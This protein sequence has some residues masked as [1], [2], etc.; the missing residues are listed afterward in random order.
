MVVIATATATG[1]PTAIVIVTAMS[2][3]AE[4]PRVRPFFLSVYFLY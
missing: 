3:E 1:F 4:A 2:N